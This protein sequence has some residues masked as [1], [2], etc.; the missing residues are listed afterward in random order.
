MHNGIGRRPLWL[1]MSDL[2]SQM[3]GMTLRSDL[4]FCLNAE[5]IPQLTESSPENE[6]KNIFLPPDKSYLEHPVEH[7]RV[8]H[9]S[10][11]KNLDSNKRSDHVPIMFRRSLE[12]FIKLSSIHAIWD[13]D[14]SVHSIPSVDGS[15]E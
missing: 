14:P 10:H 8:R 3:S 5:S 9:H 1:R 15:G 11:K 13:Y 7:I 4:Q 2:L 12:Y 6:S